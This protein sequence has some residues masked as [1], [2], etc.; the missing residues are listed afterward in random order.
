M[1]L[2]FAK[3]HDLKRLSRGGAGSMVNT[4]RQNR[5]S[6]AHF[7]GGMRGVVP[8]VFKFIGI[9][10]EIVKPALI[11]TVIDYYFLI[12]CSQHG[13]IGMFMRPRVVIFAEHVVTMVIAGAWPAGSA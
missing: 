2:V 5:P 11:R 1:V 3:F 8:K 13:A 6:K 7:S 4:L 12:S 10:I 9:V